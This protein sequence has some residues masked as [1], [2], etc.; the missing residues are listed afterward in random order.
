MAGQFCDERLQ[1]LAQLVHRHST[2]MFTLCVLNF[3]LSIVASLG[4]FLAIRAISKAS[5]MSANLKKLFLSL[6]SSD[7]AV[8]LFAQLMHGVIMA[9]MLKMAANENYNFDFLCPTVITICYLPMVFLACASFLNITVIAVDRLLAVSLHLRYQELVISRR[10]VIALVS[11]WLTSGVVSSIIVSLTKHFGIVAAVII[12]FGFLLTTVA[13]IRVYKVVRYHKNRIQ[14]QFQQ[15]N[16]QEMELH[17]EK[18]S[19]FNALFVYVVFVVCYL[20]YFCVLMLYGTNGSQSSF[21]APYF[22]TH[23]LVFLNSSLNPL[24][25]CW[26]YRE[27]RQIMKSTVKKIIG[28]SET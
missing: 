4:N 16:H 24:V 1:R 22:A 19:A 15:V 25:Y 7:L 21:L 17:R 8:G 14:S 20:P 10:V 18:R 3:I 6:A 12:F 2:F 23:F 11:L 26:R 5:S 28:I 9:V 13:N 27:I